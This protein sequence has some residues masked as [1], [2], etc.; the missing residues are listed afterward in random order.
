MHSPERSRHSTTVQSTTRTRNGGEFGKPKPRLTVERS[1]FSCP[2]R[3]FA[4]DTT[5]QTIG[6]GLCENGLREDAL[7]SKQIDILARDS[8]P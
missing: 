2:Y 8:W 5:I 3:V 1:R 7:I 6:L 4:N